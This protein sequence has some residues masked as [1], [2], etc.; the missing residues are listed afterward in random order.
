MDPL[1]KLR[2]EVL[3][4]PTVSSKFNNVPLTKGFLMVVDVGWLKVPI[5]SPN[6]SSR[7]Q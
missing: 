5:D 2:L 7:T 4:L 3:S 6:S 1:C